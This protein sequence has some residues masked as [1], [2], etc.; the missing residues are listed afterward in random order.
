MPTKYDSNKNGTPELTQDPEVRAAVDERL[1]EL[2][3]A[4]S[5]ILNVLITR[6]VKPNEEDSSRSLNSTG[7]N[8]P[9]VSEVVDDN[10][11]YDPVEEAEH[12]LEQARA[13]VSAARELR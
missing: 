3:V 1:Y 7:G 4:F 12:I 2:R 6:H 9:S 5:T 10:L 11:P 8:E 13:D